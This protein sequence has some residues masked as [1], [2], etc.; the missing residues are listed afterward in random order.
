I[1]AQTRDRAIENRFHGRF[2]SLIPDSLSAGHADIQIPTSAAVFTEI[3][4][5]GPGVGGGASRRRR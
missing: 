2:I 1:D 4:I 5:A 3:T